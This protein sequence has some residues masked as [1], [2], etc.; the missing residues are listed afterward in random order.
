MD[1]RGMSFLLILLDD[2]IEN[3]KDSFLRLE[4]DKL[5]LSFLSEDKLVLFNL[6]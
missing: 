5:S 3:K 6:D 2:L 1:F 4:Y